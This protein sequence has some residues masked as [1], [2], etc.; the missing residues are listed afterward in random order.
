M[1]M[2]LII[3]FKFL[4]LHRILS[5]RTQWR[6]KRTLEGWC[7]KCSDSCSLS[8]Y[9]ML[10]WVTRVMRWLTVE[11]IRC[12]CRSEDAVEVAH[13]G[14]LKTLR[15]VDRNSCKLD[16]MGSLHSQMGVTHANSPPDSI[17]TMKAT[18]ALSK[19][20]WCART[21]RKMVHWFMKL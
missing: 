11:L 4:Y 9:L 1:R 13:P 2:F 14:S 18:L 10:I 7:Q 8:A 17:K 5:R 20:N 6:L 12:K 15:N 16:N 21:Q 19:T 3:M